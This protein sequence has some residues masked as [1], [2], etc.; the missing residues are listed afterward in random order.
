LN[1]DGDAF[2]CIFCSLSEAVDLLYVILTTSSLGIQV[3]I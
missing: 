3:I 2:V 1:S